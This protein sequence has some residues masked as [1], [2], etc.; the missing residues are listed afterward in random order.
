MSHVRHE[1]PNIIGGEFC[2]F[3]KPFSNKNF[4]KIIVS[5]TNKIQS[6]K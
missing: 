6:E 5:I 1:T 4:N 3:E 2:R